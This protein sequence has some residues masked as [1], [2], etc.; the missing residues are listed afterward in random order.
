MKIK[1]YSLGLCLAVAFAALAPVVPVQ[2]Q[3]QTQDNA[4]LLALIEQ[5]REQLQALQAQVQAMRGEMREVR[6]EIR[7]ALREGQRGEEVRKIQELLSTDPDIYPEGLV[8]G[9]FGGLTRQALA[10]LQ[11]RHQLPATGEVDEATREVLNEYF[12]QRGSGEVPPGLLR[13]PGIMQAVERGVCDRGRGARPF[14][15]TPSPDD[16][17][18]DEDKDK[19]DK[20]DE[21]KDEE[22]RK[23]GLDVFDSL[24]GRTISDRADVINR[25]ETYHDAEATNRSVRFLNP[26]DMMTMD[27][28]ETRLNVFFDEDGVVEK[29]TCG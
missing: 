12:A 16:E 8:T 2:A 23:C 19:D 6:E 11:S 21:D 5:L 10:R 25:W 9:Y 1:L 17:K 13:A 28:I 18:K 3:E 24:V 7:T 29:V 22:L 20:K 14:C 4:A 26:G 27:Y 15:P